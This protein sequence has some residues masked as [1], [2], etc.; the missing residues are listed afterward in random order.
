M[1][2]V[3]IKKTILHFIPYDLKRREIPGRA[4]FW[5]C[6]S[7]EGINIIDMII[8]RFSTTNKDLFSYRLSEL[9]PFNESRMNGFDVLKRT[10]S[11]QQLL[12]KHQ[13]SESSSQVQPVSSIGFF[14]SSATKESC[15]IT[16][17]MKNYDM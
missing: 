1:V 13:L 15:S 6:F 2:F 10:K 7:Q 12:T 9:V 4:L 14:N 17:P 3:V 16:S 8:S 11:G 5:L